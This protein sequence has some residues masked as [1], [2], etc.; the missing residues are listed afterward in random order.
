M[1][2]IIKNL[3]A[4]FSQNFVGKFDSVCH[5]VRPKYDEEISKVEGC[6]TYARDWGLVQTDIVKNLDSIVFRIGDYSNDNISG[7]ILD[8]CQLVSLSNGVSRKV[9]L[10]VVKSTDSSIYFKVIVTEEN[11]V[12]TYTS[13]VVTKNPRKAEHTQIVL[14]NIS[15]TCSGIYHGT[16]L[17]FSNSEETSENTIPDNAAALYIDAGTMIPKKGEFF[18]IWYVKVTTDSGVILNMPLL[19]NDPN[20]NYATG[21]R[22]SVL[23]NQAR[24]PI[25]TPIAVSS[26]E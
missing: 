23:G 17:D 24:N 11:L 18:R 14:N 22:M 16:E 13:S 9:D 20:F 5:V 26:V 12:I 7:S 25:R 6:R 8:E 21:T 10:Y 15:K 1:G 3:K 4:D 2:L 19:P